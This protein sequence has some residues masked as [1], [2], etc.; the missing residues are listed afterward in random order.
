MA[1]VQFEENS[2]H[3]KDAIKNNVIAFLYEVANEI[4]SQTAR[5]YDSA[6]RVDTGQTKGSFHEISV[7]EANTSVSMGSNYE[8][9][10]WEEFGTGIHAINGDGRKDVPWKY[11]D[12]KTGQWYS[13]SGKSGH[14]PFFTAF[15]TLKPQL[16]KMISE[17]FGDLS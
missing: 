6:G 12:K 3:F 10:I 17:K 15:E 9:A 5:N 7:D 14:R 13:T 1:D 4:L 2:V 8:N 11:Q 16:E